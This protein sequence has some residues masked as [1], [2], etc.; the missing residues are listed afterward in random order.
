MSDT[1]P[2]YLS[3]Y[4]CDIVIEALCEAAMSYEAKGLKVEAKEVE[5]TMRKFQDRLSNWYV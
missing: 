3:V 1:Q 2:I 4:E 5:R